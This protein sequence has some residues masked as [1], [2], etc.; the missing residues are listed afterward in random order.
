[1]LSKWLGGHRI[2]Y[3]STELSPNYYLTLKV[4][5]FNFE[6][7]TVD[8]TCTVDV[9]SE[10]SVCLNKSSDNYNTAIRTYNKTI[11]FG[12]K[13]YKLSNLAVDLGVYKIKDNEIKIDA[14]NTEHNVDMVNSLSIDIYES[15][16]IYDSDSYLR[17]E[18]IKG[19][20]NEKTQKFETVNVWGPITKR[21]GHIYPISIKF[22]TNGK[23]ELIEK[24]RLSGDAGS[25]WT[26][27]AQLESQQ[28]S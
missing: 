18:Q 21:S 3:N 14:T 28:A 13:K 20:Y 5:D 19:S 24:I 26:T 2:E 8:L 4:F 16:D 7:G 27:R 10:V 11:G 15:T 22:N 17:Y 1:M 9:K 25:S 12:R 23:I 6:E